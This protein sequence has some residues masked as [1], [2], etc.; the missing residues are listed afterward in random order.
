MPRVEEWYVT[1]SLRWERAESGTGT[2]HRI[3]EALELQGPDKLDR[4]SELFFL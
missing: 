4:R 3:A 2:E 1:A